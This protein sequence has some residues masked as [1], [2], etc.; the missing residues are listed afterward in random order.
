[1]PGGTSLGMEILVLQLVLIELLP[2]YVL[3][4]LEAHVGSTKTN[5]MYSKSAFDYFD[6]IHFSPVTPV[7]LRT[8]ARACGGLC[9]EII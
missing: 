5:K 8:R 7:L 3:S 6:V 4:F 9:H 1:M 2:D